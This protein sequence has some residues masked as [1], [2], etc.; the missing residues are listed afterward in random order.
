MTASIAREAVL[1]AIASTGD[2]PAAVTARA[3]LMGSRFAVTVVG[4]RADQA[5]GSLALARRL[6]S[7]W[8]RFRADSEI[9]ALNLA[10]GRPLR[11]HPHTVRL[12]REMLDAHRRTD[13][14]FDPTLLPALV[15]AGYGTSRVDPSRTT[16]LPA[17]AVA[18]GR[19]D[20]VRVEGDV[21][22]LGRG[23]TLDPGGIGKGL[24]ADL[25]VTH[26]LRR[27]AL[28]AMAQ[29]GGDVVVDGLAPDGQAWRIGV[30]DP[31]DPDR[32][33]AVVRL[34]RGAVATSSVRKMRWTGPDGSDA[35][36]LLDPRGIR[37]ISTDVQTVTVIAATGARAES[38][39]K[40]G[41]LRPVDAYLAWLPQ[42]GA[43]GLAVT[44]DGAVHASPNLDDYR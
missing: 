17:S 44:A 23:T 20:A 40:S 35:H 39:T 16:L 8:S 14:D 28:G 24:A 32:Q 27:G 26:A 18:P 29:F 41:F 11:V 25:A 9:T 31:F 34:V 43:A 13:G 33:L 4:A 42:L 2:R 22:T 3:R 7:L 21:I 10:E 30:E 19:M 38:L 1:A 6:E 36:H 5:R 12:V 37:S 15:A